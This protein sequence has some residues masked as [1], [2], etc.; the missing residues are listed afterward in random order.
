MTDIAE[1]NL[2]LLASRWPRLA[3][4]IT[5]SE[6]PADVQWEAVE[7]HSTL[8]VHGHRL[9]SAYD[10]EAEARIQ[11]SI[12]PTDARSGWVSGIG[13]GD[14]LRELLKRSAL[15]ALHVV[16]LN[17]GLTH[18][19]MHVL[20]HRDWLKDTRVSLHD[21]REISN[22]PHPFAVIP[23]CL[24]L[25]DKQF[26]DLR[27]RL[28][29]E[30]ARPFEE[31][32][33]AG[34]RAMRQRYIDANLARVAEDGD[35]AELFD[36]ARGSTCCVCAAGPTLL[37]HIDW[38]RQRRDQLKLV[39]V[40]GA[41]GPLLSKDIV[42]DYV[43]SL[44][45]NPTTIIRYFEQDLS[46]CKDTTLVYT[47]IVD[48]RVPALWPGSRVVTYT[49]ENV[50]DDI[51]HRHPKGTLHVAGS[52]TNTAVDLGVRMGAKRI[53]L[54]GTDFAFPEGEIHANA[55][56]PVDFYAN[57][58]KA[59]TTTVD[60]NGKEIATLQSFNGYRIALERYIATHPAVDF[61]NASRRGARIRG[62]QY[63]N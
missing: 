24:A 58:A 26:T 20:D 14:L 48:P 57:A 34:R 59:G 32:R 56:A 9:W 52:V 3:A 51:R 10:A 6:P 18:L 27:E 46:T 39:A 31:E 30:L 25:C 54:F 62:A 13:S 21:P 44:D 63:I 55:Q 60:G 17:L 36:T 45:D 41:L 40:D 49:A 15:Q 61:I 50:Y 4:R 47:P 7:G 2:R 35:V 42:P 5:A 28:T 53:V 8:S 1:E 37:N 23:P 11:A 38:V 12:I 19:L 29:H 33:L 43:V 22:V 16:P